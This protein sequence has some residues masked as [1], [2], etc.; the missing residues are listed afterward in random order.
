MQMAR[1]LR[2]WLKWNRPV[3]SLRVRGLAGSAA[4]LLNRMA[5]SRFDAVH[6]VET[7][8]KVRANAL[9]LSPDA[10]GNEYTPVSVVALSRALRRLPINYPEWDLVDLGAGKGRALLVASHFPFRSITGIELSSYLVEIAERNIRAYKSSQQRCLSVKVLHE[11]AQTYQFSGSKVVL[12][13]F[14]PFSSPVAM[15][16]VLQNLRIWLGGGARGL[17]VIYWNP[18]FRNLNKSL[19]L[20][21]DL[22]LVEATPMYC[23]YSNDH[24][25]C[26]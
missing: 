19:E 1:R 3:T 15:D 26:L 21:G 4:H 7:A 25:A 10:H 24:H 14:D 18:R 5:D 20:L 22:K 9:G 13:L 8:T 16:T 23:W 12:Y 2:L 17:H 6:G 11:D